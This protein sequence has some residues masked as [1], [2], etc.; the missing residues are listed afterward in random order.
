MNSEFWNIFQGNPNGFSDRNCSESGWEIRVRGT[1]LTNTKLKTNYK[2]Q[3]K[4]KTFHKITRIHIKLQKITK[5]HKKS[6]QIT[7]VL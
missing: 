4:L 7:K 6:Q 5:I 1:N 2:Q 3:A